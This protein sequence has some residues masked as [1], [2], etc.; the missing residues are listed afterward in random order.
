MRRGNKSEKKREGASLQLECGAFYLMSN[1]TD[2]GSERDFLQ[3]ITPIYSRRHGS[4]V[5]FRVSS[6]SQVLPGDP[7]AFQIMDGRE[8]VPVY[9]Q[10]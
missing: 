5:P 2:A 1:R 7:G 10:T 3:C 6:G 4:L 9:H 8:E